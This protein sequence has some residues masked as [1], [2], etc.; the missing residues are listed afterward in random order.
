MDSEEKAVRKP[1]WYISW[2]FFLWVSGGTIQRVI[3]TPH[4]TILTN[5]LGAIKEQ[6]KDNKIKK[7]KHQLM[8]PALTI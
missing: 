6:S 4:K 2:H 8:P 5:H 7:I 3:E 1:P